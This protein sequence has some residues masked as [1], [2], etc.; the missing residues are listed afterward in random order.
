MEEQIYELINMLCELSDR[1]LDT[2]IKARLSKL[3][4]KTIEDIK[5]VILDCINDCQTY[6]LSSAFEINAMKLM[7]ENMLNGSPD[8]YGAKIMNEKLN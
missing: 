1:Q 7:Y 3:N 8:D 5:P 4:G 2:K 6:S